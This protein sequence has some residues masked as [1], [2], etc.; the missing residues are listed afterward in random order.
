M[1]EQ[2]RDVYRE[3]RPE[4]AEENQA[5]RQ[6]DATPDAGAGPE[7]DLLRGG[8][9]RGNRGSTANGVSAEDD[10]DGELRKRQ[11]REGADL[12]SGMD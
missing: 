9:P 12:V 7:G 1:T 4:D 2:K 11:Y 10:A 5:Q 3:R 8:E 6:S